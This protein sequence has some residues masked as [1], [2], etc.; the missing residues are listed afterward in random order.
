MG[1]GFPSF[2]LRSCPPLVLPPSFSL[3]SPVLSLVV[4]HSLHHSLFL[5]TLGFPVRLS[6]GEG[7]REGRGRENY[8]SPASLFN[9]AT[10]FLNVDRIDIKSCAAIH[11]D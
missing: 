4:I 10:V 11:P 5:T 7:G 3:P 6:V 8:N 1:K 9:A 2:L